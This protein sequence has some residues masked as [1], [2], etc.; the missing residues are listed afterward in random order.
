MRCEDNKV[1]PEYSDL[2]KTQ[3]AYRTAD[4]VCWLGNW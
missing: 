3:D 2:Y 4:Y 1:E